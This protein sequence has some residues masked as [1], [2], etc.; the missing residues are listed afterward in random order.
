MKGGIGSCHDVA[1]A[2]QDFLQ[3]HFGLVLLVNFGINQPKI[4][5]ADGK[6]VARF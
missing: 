4:L 1:A 5:S 6:A 3:H 2:I